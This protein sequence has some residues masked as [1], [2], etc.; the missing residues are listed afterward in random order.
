MTKNKDEEEEEDFDEGMFSDNMQYNEQYY[1]NLI[2]QYNQ[3][4]RYKDDLSQYIKS[5][6]ELIFIK[7]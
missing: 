4:P 1:N 2:K 3:D 6:L 7:K 5:R